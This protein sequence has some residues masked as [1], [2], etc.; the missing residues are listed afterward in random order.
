MTA[1]NVVRFPTA[2]GVIPQVS[3]IEAEQAV[4]GAALVNPA[5]ARLCPWLAAEDFFEPVHG[6]VWAAILEAVERGQ[7]ADPVTLKR[8]FD[9]DASLA[10][11][12]GARYIAQL[13]AVAC[14]VREAV[15]YARHV[16][17]TARMRALF[18]VADELRTAAADPSLT[19]DPASIIA[20][21]RARMDV[22]CLDETQAVARSAM[23]V[24]DEI[25]AE[26]ENPRR[27]W[28]TG[29]PSLNESFGGGLPEGYVVGIEGRPKQGK[30]VVLQTLALAMA[31][32]RVPTCYLAL[33]MGSARIVQRML[34]SV[35]GF[36][37]AMF[38]HAD[39]YLL[40]RV[41][42]SRGAIDSLPLYL[43][44]CPAIRFSRL[45]ALADQLMQVNG[46]RVFVLDYWQLVKPDGRVTNRAE[47][48]ADVAQWCADHAAEHG[49]TWLVASQEN[50]TGE[51]YGSDGLVKACDWLA[52]IEKHERR[53]GHP[54]LGMVETVWLDVRYARD[55]SGDP[56]GSPDFPTLMLNPLGPQLEEISA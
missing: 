28:D 3:A 8:M 46:I 36:N 32:N 41:N 4:L 37:S 22:L 2:E 21:A 12:D 6:R 27:Y 33:E 43:T 13:A 5:A 1:S 47:F 30:S 39:D 35:G 29:L 45:Q 15:D 24:V 40:Q 26:I 49:T 54:T 9:Q 19:A 11:L 52:G 23:Q 48:L 34:A 31:R 42:R 14:P 25:V 53:F 50:R 51:S 56:I 17:R 44:N 10:E 20:S 18:Q 7:R 16:K 55:G 38:R